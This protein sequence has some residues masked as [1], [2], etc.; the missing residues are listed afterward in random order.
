[1]RSSAQSGSVYVHTPFSPVVPALGIL[2][3]GYLMWSLPFDT[4]LRLVVWMAI[5][6][7]LTGVVTAVGGATGAVAG[8]VAITP[9]SG[10]AGIPGARAR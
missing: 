7:I 10:T 1:M 4:W 8:L 2:S 5:E 6:K 9:A 3:C